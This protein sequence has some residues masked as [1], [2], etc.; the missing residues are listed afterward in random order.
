MAGQAIPGVRRVEAGPRRAVGPRPG[1]LRTKLGTWMG[2]RMPPMLRAMT[3][4]LLAEMR[5]IQWFHQIRLDDHTVTPG[6]CSHTAAD[7]TLRFG[8]PEALRGKT[9]LDIGAWDGL[10]SFEAERRGAAVTAL[11]TT[12]ERGGNW[13]G[14]AGFE[15]AKRQ[16]GSRVEFRPGSVHDLDPA[17]HGRYDYVF[18]FGVL[19]HLTDPVDALRRVFAVTRECC[20]IE[21][22]ISIHPD[23]L[24]RPIWEFLPGHD[25]DPTNYWYPTVAGLAAMLRWVGFAEANVLY[26]QNGRMTVRALTSAAAA[27]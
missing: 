11:D 17:V 6:K 24:Q 9:V 15:F 10:F 13:G 7:A 25:N 27:G 20:L 26:A 5:A 8:L 4:E 19:Y 1:A 3:P 2:A 16:L 18:F 23:G 22:T 12:P 21:T 14:T